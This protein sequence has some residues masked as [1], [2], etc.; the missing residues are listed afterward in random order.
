MIA[1]NRIDDDFGAGEGEDKDSD[2]VDRFGL[3]GLSVGLNMERSFPPPFAF[4]GDFATL[5]LDGFRPGEKRDNDIAFGLCGDGERGKRDG[6]KRAEVFAL[7]A[8]GGEEGGLSR[9]SKGGCGCDFLPRY[10]VF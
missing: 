6:A 3:R 9:H 8:S 4:L 5:T 1:G 10:V 7:G 2:D